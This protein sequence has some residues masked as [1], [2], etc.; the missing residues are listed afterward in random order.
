LTKVLF[1]GTAPQALALARQW[2]VDVVAVDKAGRL[3]ASAGWA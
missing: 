2:G 3:H 1:M